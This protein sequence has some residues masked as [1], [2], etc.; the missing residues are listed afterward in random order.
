MFEIPSPSDMKM[1]LLLNDPKMLAFLW[2]WRLATAPPGTVRTEKLITFHRE[3]ENKVALMLREEET[4]KILRTS[5]E[6]LLRGAVV[7]LRKGLAV[8]YALPSSPE[9]LVRVLIERFKAGDM[10]YD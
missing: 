10:R 6:D 4:E 5:M 3:I 8:Q 2:Q 9:K 1:R 7:P